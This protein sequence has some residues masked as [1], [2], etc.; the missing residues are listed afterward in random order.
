MRKQWLI[1][2]V[3]GFAAA[4]G[5]AFVAVRGVG[6]APA[7]AAS[8]VGDT[9][10]ISTAPANPASYPSGQPIAFSHDLHAGTYHIP[11]R[12]CHFSAGR[13]S[14]AG[15]P[16]VSVCMDCHTV[17]DGSGHPEE[18]A[19][20]R[21]YWKQRRPIPWVRIDEIA[22]HAHFPHMVHVH[23]GISCRTCHRK[24]QDTH[25]LDEANPLRGGDDMGWCV[26][27]HRAMG[28]ST[29]CSRCHY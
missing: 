15:M 17:I 12:Y 21:A 16:S 3:V 20:L 14:D 6:R 9:A 18:I 2:G 27:C 25:V 4:A 8:S 22:D 23:A 11:C 5:L 24:V 26:R 29:D 10:E 13:S 1:G 7:R 19:R 28:A